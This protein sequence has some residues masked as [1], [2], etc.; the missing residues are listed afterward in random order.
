MCLV[1]P[2]LS[3]RH[4]ESLLKYRGQ[5]LVYAASYRVKSRRI[6]IILNI[7]NLLRWEPGGRGARPIATQPPY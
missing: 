6:L 7:L 4:C 1:K 3:P 5:S 2:N